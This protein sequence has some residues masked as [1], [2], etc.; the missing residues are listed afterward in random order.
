MTLRQIG[1]GQAG[2]RTAPATGACRAALSV[3]EKL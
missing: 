3:T 1:F 2:A